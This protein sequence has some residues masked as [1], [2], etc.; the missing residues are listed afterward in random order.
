MRRD[1]RRD[2]LEGERDEKDEE[3]ELDEMRKRERERKREKE[4]EVSDFLDTPKKKR[5]ARLAQ[6]PACNIRDMSSAN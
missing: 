6:G 1:Q 4:R 3:D 2:E 5:K